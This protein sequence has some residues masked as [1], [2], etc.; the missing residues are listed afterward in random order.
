MIRGRRRGIIGPLALGDRPA[1]ALLDRPVLVS[2]LVA[3][4]AWLVLLA[5]ITSW[6]L[7]LLGAAY[8]AVASAFLAA[9][10]ARDSL[11]WRQEGL[12]WVAPW[13]LAVAL[14]AWIG[15]HI[16]G[17]SSGGVEDQ[18]LIWWF[19]LIIGTGCYA[20]WQLSALAIRKLV[21]ARS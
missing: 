10:Y 13:V 16:G 4:A 6:V 15:A 2:N 17:G 21:T 3:G 11:T 14:W 18:L 8:V 9:V 5:L 1:A 7:A 12:A 20:A 19:G